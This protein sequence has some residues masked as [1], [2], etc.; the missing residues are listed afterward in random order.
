MPIGETS[1]PRNTPTPARRLKVIANTR[2]HEPSFVLVED[3][4]VVDPAFQ[5]LMLAYLRDFSSRTV[6]AYAYDLLIFYRFLRDSHI[7]AEELQSHHI[8]RFVLSQRKQKAAPRTINHRLTIVRS[9]LNAQY[10]KLGDKIF[11]DPSPILYKGQRNTALLG[12][13]WLKGNKRSSWKIKVPVH[14]IA[15]LTSREVQILLGGIK[16]CRDRAIIFLMLFCGLRSFEIL[17]TEL[18]DIDFIDSTVRIRGKGRR[19]RILPLSPLVKKTLKVYLDHERPEEC[20]HDTYFVLL[21]GKGR[22]QP[23]NAEALRRFFRYRRRA[24]K[25]IHPHLLRHTFCTQLM[26]QGVSIPV[27]QKLMGHTDIQTT[28]AY[29]HM[30]WNHV[31]KE[32]H[33]AVEALQK[34]YDVD[35]G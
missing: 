32:Y 30:D 20:P 26:A 10:N 12:K 33:Q 24:I 8:A 5:F 17:G 19:E 34:T 31:C 14:I 7:V 1:M 21:K 9:F 29:T 15:P 2:P 6:R 28:M 18:N 3:G 23:M 13:T 16:R 11:P 22:G 4:H 27:V 35:K 25:R